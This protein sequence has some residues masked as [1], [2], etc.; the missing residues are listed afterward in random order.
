MAPHREDGRALVL[1][2]GLLVVE[3]EA[4]ADDAAGRLDRV[5]CGGGSAL[6]LEEDG[7]PELVLRVQ[8]R[9][10]SRSRTVTSGAA[11]VKARSAVAATTTAV[12]PIS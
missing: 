2:S 5:V 10:R 6:G 8:E 7:L 11:A 12:M 1:A 4:P 3:D 9:L